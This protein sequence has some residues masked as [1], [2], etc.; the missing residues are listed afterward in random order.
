[1]TQARRAIAQVLS[2]AETPL[3][4]QD[5]YERGR[6]LHPGLGLVTVYRTLELFEELSL[7]SRVHHGEG[8][9]GYL[10][11]SPGHRHVLIC[12]SCG[13]AMEFPGG[14]D[15]ERLIGWVERETGY[16]VDGHLLQLTGVCPGCQE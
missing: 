14:D 1:M 13:R 3:A 8:C 4:P 10:M 12:R 5:I 9:H 11:S 16:Q 6:A 7:V 2:A 15:L